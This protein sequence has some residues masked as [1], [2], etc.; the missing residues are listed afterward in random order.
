MQ[1]ITNANRGKLFTIEAKLRNKQE[2]K[3]TIKETLEIKGNKKEISWLEACETPVTDEEHG[4]KDDV[5]QDNILDELNSF[6]AEEF[7]ED[8]LNDFE[9][10]KKE[11]DVEAIDEEIID[12]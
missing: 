4:V 2:I 11:N 8:D 6:Y 7:V 9:E 3:G 12:F 1:E 5:K 10:A